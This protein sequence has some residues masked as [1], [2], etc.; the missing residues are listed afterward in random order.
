MRS[1]RAVL[2]VIAAF[3]LI[4]AS[5]GSAVAGTTAASAPNDKYWKLQWG[6]AQVKAPQAWSTSKGAGQTVSIVDTGI[7][8]DHPDLASKIPGEQDR[9][10]QDLHRLRRLWVRQR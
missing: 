5:V 6:P 9:W 1:T 10:W 4:L 2:T 7:D 8:L 3:A